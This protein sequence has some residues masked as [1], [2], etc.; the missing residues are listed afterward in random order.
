MSTCPRPHCGCIKRAV[1]FFV[2]G[3]EAT[4]VVARCGAR[5]QS[6]VR[7]REDDVALGI[8]ILELSRCCSFSLSRV[9]SHRVPIATPPACRYHQLRESREYCYLVPDVA[10]GQSEGRLGGHRFGTRPFIPALPAGPKSR[11]RS[12]QT[13]ALKWIDQ[14]QRRL[15]LREIR[16]REI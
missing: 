13:G 1:Y 10:L 15:L 3:G 6:V 11:T 9:V 16:E 14:S 5:L 12:R 2:M 7:R 4:L 8:C